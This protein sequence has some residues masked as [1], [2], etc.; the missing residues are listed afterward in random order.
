MTFSSLLNCC[1][2]PRSCIRMCIRLRFLHLFLPLAV[3]PLFIALTRM[4][5]FMALY[6]AFP[7][8]PVILR[9]DSSYSTTAI[10]DLFRCTV[11]IPGILQAVRERRA[12]LYAYSVHLRMTFSRSAVLR[13][14]PFLF[15]LYPHLCSSIICFLSS[16]ILSSGSSG[17]RIP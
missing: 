10:I 14:N 4:Q 2:P 3:Q 15:Y 5:A 12:K 1:H 6:M 9:N 8:V 13:G 7:L 17:S 16:C 11:R